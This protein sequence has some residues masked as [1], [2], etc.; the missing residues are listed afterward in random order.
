MAITKVIMATHNKG[1]VTE[2]NQL[3]AGAGVSI[4]SLS[5]AGITHD[6][7]EDQDTFVGNALKKAREIV[8]LTGEWAIAD[9]SGLCIQ[10]LDDAPGVYTARWAGE[11]ASDD[12]LIRHTLE[13]LKDAPDLDRLAV[14]K[15]VAVLVS[16]DG[17]EF[18]FEGEVLGE[19]L[20]E[21]I[22]EYKPGLPY[23]A[24]FK[25]AGFSVPFTQMTDAEKN[26]VSHRGRAFRKLAEFIK[27]EGPFLD[28]EPRIL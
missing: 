7:I 25:P 26:A 20:K 18:V 1:K 10:H 4:V 11:G 8:E 16:P 21:P 14:F 9:D 2:I 6:T 17:R 27:T 12:D 5:E 13:Q 23:D 22:G 19:I 24:I 28:G 15:A 3:L